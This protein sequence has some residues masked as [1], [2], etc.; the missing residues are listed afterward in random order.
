MSKTFG[1]EI[2]NFLLEIGVLIAVGMNFGLYGISW[3]LPLSLLSWVDVGYLLV[4]LTAA[5]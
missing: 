3:R 2:S 5:R 4:Q 1:S